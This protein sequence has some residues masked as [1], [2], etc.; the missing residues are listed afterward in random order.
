MSKRGGLLYASSL[1]QEAAFLEQL[2]LN[3]EV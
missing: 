3:I 1:K 2:L